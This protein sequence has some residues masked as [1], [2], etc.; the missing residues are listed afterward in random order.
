[1]KNVSTMGGSCWFSGKEVPCELSKL[2]G[3]LSVP[4]PVVDRSISICCEVVA[5]KLIRKRPLSVIAASS[6]YAACREG[7]SPVTL[8]ELAA[9]IHAAP[10]DVGRCY[11][12]IRDK[13]HLVPPSPSGPAYATKVA[14]RVQASEEAT[15][16]S[17]EVEK[18]ASA[19]GFDV[20]SP[21]T[22]A[23][24]AVYL[25]CLATGEEVRQSD[26]AEAAGVS[27]ISMRECTKLMR[28][29][30][31][32]PPA[33]QTESQQRTVGPTSDSD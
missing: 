3:G 13:L 30:F 14:A 9:A 28:R 17:V 15:T 1:L 31:D 5:K 2:M 23:A 27:V 33:E 20:R 21:M 29:F 6:S 24:A 7:N 11:I 22:M 18:R 12:L 26:V 10:E 32:P 16:L 19:E 25:A 8:K 4:K